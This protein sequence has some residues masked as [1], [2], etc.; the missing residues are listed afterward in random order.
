MSVSSHLGIDLREYDGRIRT[1]I[2]DYEEMLD[3]AAAALPP[4]TRRLLDLGTGT[5]ALAARCLARA[6][7]ARV[8]GIDA[9]ASMLKIAEQRLHRYRATFLCGSFL[10]VPLPRADAIVASF[11]LHHVRTRPAKV[12]LFR[13]IRTAMGRGGRLVTVDCHPAADRA[14]ARAQRDAWSDHLRRFYTPAKARGF[15]DAW[16]DE[17]VYVPLE[18]ELDLLAAG[19]LHGEVV[20]RKGAF[21]VIR[22]STDT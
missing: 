12:A 2:P 9:D 3:A 1:F 22:A 13:R 7:R 21:A 16:S 19:G 11:A 14:L 20:W 18:T 8:V 15:L 17:D 4:G 10:R 5:G 6:T